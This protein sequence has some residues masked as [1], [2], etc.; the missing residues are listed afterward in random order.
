LPE[1]GR[2]RVMIRNRAWDRV[3]VRVRVRD[4]VG[5]RDWVSFRVRLR[6][7]TSKYYSTI[8]STSSISGVVVRA[9][10]SFSRAEKRPQAHHRRRTAYSTDR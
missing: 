9:V 5:F 7:R 6:I 10:V 4:R 2:V 3:R 1:Q 8:S